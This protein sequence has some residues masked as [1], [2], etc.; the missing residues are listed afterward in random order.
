MEEVVLFA[1]GP[2]KVTTA[3]I[4]GGGHDIP[5]PEVSAAFVRASSRSLRLVL[6]GLALGFSGFVAFAFGSMCPA[7]TESPLPFLLLGVA[8]LIWSVVVFVKAAFQAYPLHRELVLTVSGR[9]ISLVTS[10]N[11]ALLL[12]AAKAI[13]G[14][15]PAS[16]VSTS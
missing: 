15:L 3:W 7:I 6:T 11:L 8:L 13:T 14:S 9:N 1:E 12:R 2:V 4:T 10:T 5:L 16:G